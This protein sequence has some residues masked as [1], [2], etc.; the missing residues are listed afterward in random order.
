MA[1]LNSNKNNRT[2]VGFWIW[3]QFDG[4][5]DEVCQSLQ[6]RVQK[7]IKSPLFGGHLTISG[8][9]THIDQ[10]FIR[11]FDGLGDILSP[12]PIFIESYSFSE[13]YF[14]SF[15]LKVISD[16]NLLRVK[17]KIDIAFGAK[18]NIDN[19]SPH[20]SLA[21]GNATAEKKIECI[22]TLPELQKS[23]IVT[24]LSLIRAD[25]ISEK[26]DLI[27]EITLREITI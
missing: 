26:W 1:S 12:F 10:N 6:F 11:K 18:P 24:K 3:L 19:F 22:E 2:N 27:K 23:F 16:K 9:F 5:S 21:Y 7:I 8:P 15:F 13:E 20:I 25:E 17:N 14:E 4:F